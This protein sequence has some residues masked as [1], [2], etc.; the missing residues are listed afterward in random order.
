MTHR[1]SPAPARVRRRTVLGALAAVVA[2]LAPRRA[3]ARSR[4]ARADQS[5]EQSPGQPTEPKR[6]IWIGHL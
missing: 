2:A 1:E 6:P 4:D 3:L 5:A